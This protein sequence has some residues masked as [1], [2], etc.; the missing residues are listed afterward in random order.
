MRKRN[1]HNMVIQN[2]DTGEFFI[3]TNSRDW[4]ARLANWKHDHLLNRKTETPA[5]MPSGHIMF[6]NAGSRADRYRIVSF[7][8]I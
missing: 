7:E 8:D 5:P 6:K 3:S 4:S 2:N 1:T